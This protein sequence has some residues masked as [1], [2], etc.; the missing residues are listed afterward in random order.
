MY[1][2]SIGVPEYESLTT[3]INEIKANGEMLNLFLKQ[4]LKSKSVSTP[5]K[6]KRS[7]TKEKTHK[8]YITPRQLG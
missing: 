2:K 5:M 4:R 1:R 7:P 3:F 8:M 6:E